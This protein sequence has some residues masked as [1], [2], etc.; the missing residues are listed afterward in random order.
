MAEKRHRWTPEEKQFVL[1]EMNTLLGLRLNKRDASS[2]V[3]D[4]MA[5][6]FDAD[7]SAKGVETMHRGL[8]TGRRTVE[9]RR[10]GGRR[11]GWKA[12]R[13]S[14][15]DEKNVVGAVEKLI[16]EGEGTGP[17]SSLWERVSHVMAWHGATVTPMACY[18]RWRQ[19]VHPP[20]SEPEPEPETELEH[21][22]R[23]MPSPI[24]HKDLAEMNQPVNGQAM[25]PVTLRDFMREMNQPKLQPRPDQME[26]LG[27]IK[28]IEG[29]ADPLVI[30]LLEDIRAAAVKTNGLLKQLVEGL[31]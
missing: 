6:V 14:K 7:V 5:D 30:S 26:L 12:H 13:W 23:L 3:A 28:I 8:L 24:P 11:G 18:Q 17:S 19:L 15:D 2:R 21:Q 25:S 16:K 31:T 22:P 1:D 27:A 20:K 9:G 29:K 4:Q 10:I